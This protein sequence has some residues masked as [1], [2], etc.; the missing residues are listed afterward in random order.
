MSLERN[1][2]TCR[3]TNP[4]FSP[5]FTKFTLLTPTET[6]TK[7]FF[8]PQGTGKS[9]FGKKEKSVWRQNTSQRRI[10][11]RLFLTTQRFPV[12]KQMH[13][14][15]TTT[16]N[17]IIGRCY[18]YQR[19]RMSAWFFIRRQSS[20]TTQFPKVRTTIWSVFAQTIIIRPPLQDSIPSSFQSPPPLFSFT[21]HQPLINFSYLFYTIYH[22]KSTT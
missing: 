11:L 18:K 12:L 22:R 10:A 19:P 9:L 16:I 1:F 15:A 7:K 13:W 6:T 3:K 21:P 17:E 8:L 14:A 20:I 4:P 2:Q 5:F